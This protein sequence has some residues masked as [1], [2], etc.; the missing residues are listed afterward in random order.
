MEPLFKSYKRDNAFIH[1]PSSTFTRS[2]P[3]VSLSG[4]SISS[5]AGLS[6]LFLLGDNEIAS[7]E[8]DQLAFLRYVHDSPVHVHLFLSLH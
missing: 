2:D 1:R 4:P 5:L 6:P 3:R 8:S 7:E